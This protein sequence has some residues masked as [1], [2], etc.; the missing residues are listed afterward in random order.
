MSETEG[1]A[2]P[3]HVLAE[4]LAGLDLDAVPPTAREH[5]TNLL[6]DAIIC[7]LAADHA[8]DT[9]P[10]AAMANGIG[11]P[12]ASTVVGEPERRALANAVLLN[13]FRMTAVTA[14]DVFAPAELHSTPAVVP[15]VLALAERDGTSGRTVLTAVVAGLEAAVR[16][17]SAFDRS[18]WRARG[19][20][21]PGVI[22]PFGSAAGAAVVLGLDAG[23]TRHA[24]A[25]AA[26]QAAGTWAQRGSPTVKFHQ[27]RA[28]LAGSMAAMLAAEGFTGAREIMTAKE[29][30]MFTAYAAEDAALGLDGLG[31]TW[32]LE[33]ISIRLWPGGARVQ[34]SMAAAAQIVRDAAPAWEAID[35]V[36]I[37]VAPAIATAQSWAAE[38]ASTFAALASLPF[39]VAVTLRHGSAAPAY[40][41]EAGYGDADLRA[42][43]SG[44]LEVVGDESMPP[45][46]ARVAVTT[47]D[48]VRHEASV[49]IPRGDPRSP[50]TVDELASKAHDFGDDAIG[51]D[52][53]DELIGRVR[54]ITQE[55]DL[56]AILSLVRPPTPAA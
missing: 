55:A 35:R 19:W 38:P 13:G 43:M 25:M 9:A 47:V 44:R 6:L 50:A 20:H 16:L 51:R 27:A 39:T 36:E 14:C 41:T 34:P 2:D 11:G 22:G 49:D 31:T 32:L 37:R 12:G 28:A 46:G 40:F 26:S 8:E 30:G 54:G 21:S 17:A 53:V 15:G 42:F 18:E 1:R 48:G 4:E 7:A 5:A 3:T 24:L 29:G 10:F 52:A 33:Q 23:A 45:L 56:R